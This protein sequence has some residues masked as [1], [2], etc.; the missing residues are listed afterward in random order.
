MLLAEHHRD[1]RFV[2]CLCAIA[3]IPFLPALSGGFTNWDDDV[4]V[5]NNPY[6]HAGV[7]D[8]LLPL[9]TRSYWSLY[10]PV[11]YAL[12]WAG[13]HLW[14]SAAAGY[15]LLNLACHL[16]SAVLFYQ[17]LKSI[18]KSRWAALLA[19]A[20]WALQPLQVEP[21]A[22]I[23]GL[24]DVLSGMLALACW[25]LYIAWREQPAGVSAVAR[26]RLLFCA[27]GL[28]F[29]LACLAK[30]SVVLFPLVLAGYDLLIG[31]RKWRELAP[32][33]LFLAVSILTVVVTLKVQ[34]PEQGGV[35]IPGGAVPRLL[36]MADSAAFYLE[37]LSWPASLCPVYARGIEH[38]LRMPEAAIRLACLCAAVLIV[39]WLGRRWWLGAIV[40]V[41]GW[42]PVSGLVPFGYLAVSSVADRYAYLPALGAALAVGDLI[43]RFDRGKEGPA[44]WPAMLARGLACLWIVVFAALTWSQTAVWNN[45]V[46]VWAWTLDCNPHPGARVLANYGSALYHRSEEFSRD[47]RKEDAR[48]TL[49]DASHV[50]EGCVS[51]YPDH[52]PGH[53]NLALVLQAQ[54]DY[55]AA[56]AECMTALDEDPTH[57]DYWVALGAMDA[58]MKDYA[59]CVEASQHALSLDPRDAMAALNLG[60]AEMELNRP[61][62]AARALAIAVEADPED[63]ETRFQFAVALG[64]SGRADEANAEFSK[65]AAGPPDKVSRLLRAS[66]AANLNGP[67][68]TDR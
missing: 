36:I 4:N 43:S 34:Q 65:V 10:I 48:H 46:A 17:I 58:A 16:V 55:Q 37:K 61:A 47:G 3:A 41:A 50:L 24:K 49:E 5:T 20:W 31:G 26:R 15:H 38:G 40:F 28:A 9:L 13:Y 44:E 8:G 62:E 66:A 68:R 35:Q 42:A 1:F 19:S 30:P 54:G 14:G 23:T 32:L 57:P 2:L 6:V 33:A 18:L 11:T 39:A 64:M 67:S 12:F 45:S 25:R 63:Y 27:S 29:L 53:Y 21:V 51:E 52:A 22:W 56:R 60:L 59:G 7:R